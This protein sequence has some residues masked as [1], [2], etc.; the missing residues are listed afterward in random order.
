MNILATL[1]SLAAAAL[2]LAL[3]AGPA[4]AQGLPGAPAPFDKGGVDIAVVGYLFAG[5]FP[6]AY[7]RGVER[8]AKALGARL[9]TFDA[10][11]QADSQRAMLE[12]AI[13]LKVDGIIVS[14]GL[15]ETLHDTVRQALDKGIKVVA[16][17]IELGLPG[18]IQI[19]QD[20]HEL[21]RLALRQALADNGDSFAAGYAYIGGFTPMERRDEIWSQV[22]R[23]HPGIVEKARFGTLAPPVANSVANQASAALRANPDIS[24]I[25]A[26]YDEFAKGAKI[27]IDEAGLSRRVKIYSADISTADIQLMKEPDSAWVA[28][29]AVNPEVAGAISVRALALAIAGQAPGSRI[30]VPPALVTRQ[31]LLALE[32]NNVRQLAERLPA[33][34]QAAR[35]AR[36]AWMPLP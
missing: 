22:K 30:Q 15:A 9:R 35:I 19:E 36:P 6:E 28:T 20:H 34:G 25:F 27:A 24:V 17:D 23:E 12:Q 8:Q 26:P 13:D 3:G 7:L 33:F 14:L 10:R 29:A 31:Q 1:K 4:V 16:F 18:V 11:A 2:A 5:D 21:A 32:V